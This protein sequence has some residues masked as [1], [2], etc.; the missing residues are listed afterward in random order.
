MFNNLRLFFLT[1]KFT[2][3]KYMLMKKMHVLDKKTM[4]KF[5]VVKLTTPAHVFFEEQFDLWC[6]YIY[7]ENPELLK[8]FSCG[9]AVLFLLS[10]W[11]NNKLNELQNDLSNIGI[12]TDTDIALYLKHLETSY[13]SKYV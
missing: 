7:N 10:N 5:S 4:K 11:P 3:K 1:S 2:F 13:Y 9:L 6:K 8:T 12:K